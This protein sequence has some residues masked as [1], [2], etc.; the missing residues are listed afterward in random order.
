MIM[1]AQHHDHV[2]HNV[3]HHGRWKF[4]DQRIRYG[5]GCVAPV[6]QRE[7]E[8]VH[9]GHVF[10][11]FAFESALDVVAVPHHGGIC[12]SVR[13]HRYDGHASFWEGTS[14]FVIVGRYR[15]VEPERNAIC[16][17]ECIFTMRLGEHNVTVG[18]AGSERY[19]YGNQFYAFHT[20]EFFA[21]ESVESVGGWICLYGPVSAVDDELSFYTFAVFF[22]A[23]LFR[24]YAGWYGRYVWVMPVT[25]VCV[26]FIV[27]FDVFFEKQ[28]ITSVR[29]HVYFYLFLK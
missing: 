8:S 7:R 19:Q 29:R 20:F 13:H 2:V 14:G 16:K 25:F 5:Y 18:E 3:R 28:W 23:V 26:S 21:Q 1:H 6:P 24:I 4:V 22:A 27:S 17:H 11:Y 15:G 12:E 10:S 9:V